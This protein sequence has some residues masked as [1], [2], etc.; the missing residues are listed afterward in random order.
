MLTFAIFMLIGL[1]FTFLIPETKGKSLEEISEG[2]EKS[3]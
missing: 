3:N 1:G 2:Q